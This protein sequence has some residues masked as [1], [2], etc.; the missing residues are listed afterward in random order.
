MKGKIDRLIRTIK[1]VQL[2]FVVSGKVDA[3]L[4]VNSIKEVKRFNQYAR[5][6]SFFFSNADE[7]NTSFY[8]VGKTKSFD[9]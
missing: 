9:V 7:A 2:K 1:N 6:F 5:T 4:V 3:P 8:N